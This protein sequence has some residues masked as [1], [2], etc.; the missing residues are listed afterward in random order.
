METYRPVTGDIGLVKTSRKKMRAR[1]VACE[2]ATFDGGQCCIRKET[3]ALKEILRQAPES[4]YPSASHVEDLRR[5]LAFHGVAYE[6]PE[7]LATIEAKLTDSGA[8]RADLSALAQRISGKEH[9]AVTDGEML[10]LI[11]SAAAGTEAV[12]LPMHPSTRADKPQPTTLL[13]ETGAPDPPVSPA[14]TPPSFAAGPSLDALAAPG[15]AKATT[16]SEGSQRRLELAITEL[17]LYLDDIDRRIGR[18]EPHL[19]DISRIVRDAA[20]RL[21]AP[22]FSAEQLQTVPKELESSVS[23]PA[24]EIEPDLKHRGSPSPE[25]VGPTLPNLP[26]VTTG[27]LSQHAQ[28]PVE[29]I[30]F[31]GR[32]QHGSPD[33]TAFSVTHSRS[34]RNLRETT[35]KVLA[36]VAVLLA[37]VGGI[38][39]MY[40]LD[41]SGEDAK[42]AQPVTQSATPTA[43]RGGSAPG[44]SEP[45][46]PPIDAEPAPP[47]RPQAESGHG[48][49]LQSSATLPKAPPL[50]STPNPAPNRGVG[51]SVRAKVAGKRSE[52]L[53]REPRIEVLP[54]A[55]PAQR[56]AIAAEA[57]AAQHVAS[58][59]GSETVSKLASGRLPPIS[60]SPGSGT[61]EVELHSSL[62][63][64]LLVSRK[65][66]YPPDALSQHK[67]GTVILDA[68]IAKDGSVKR[69]DV[70]EGSEGFTRSALNAVS[71]WRYKPNHAHGEPSETQ[72]RITVNYRIR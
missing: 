13:S 11:Q 51:S 27:L 44:I 28:L 1:N 23:P 36:V 8:F 63:A 59:S 24:I 3:Y 16:E 7:G 66:V 22:R 31:A 21:Q 34:H 57:P 2:Y 5:L 32:A 45:I 67:Q 53:P 46:A 40:S 62:E 60:A 20:D 18:I 15:V 14:R 54:T 29:H 25:G 6:A 71:W 38:A 50:P 4:F 37:I 41:K 49:R 55:K 64:A 61:P 56:G 52:P 47:V 72:A 69:M 26:S 35:G 39:A 10:T 19:E 43:D 68:L 17:K 30:A 33:L 12:E 48:N 70:V 65:P 9:R 42:T 58:R